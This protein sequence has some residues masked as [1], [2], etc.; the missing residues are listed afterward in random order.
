MRCFAATLLVLTMMRV[1]FFVLFMI[2]ATGATTTTVGTR[3]TSS[4]FMRIEL[5]LLPR[6]GEGRS[7]LR[8]AAAC[9]VQG[10]G[11]EPRTDGGLVVGVQRG[12]RLPPV[13]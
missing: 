2:V 9:F 10:R 5:P 4:R 12:T 7:H 6:L 3:S 11:G 8:V 1:L 13:L